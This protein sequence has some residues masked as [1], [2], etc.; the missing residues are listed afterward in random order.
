MWYEIITIGYTP[1]SSVLRSRMR[2]PSDSGS[3]SAVSTAA[4]AASA[5]YSTYSS[6]TPTATVDKP[7][8]W[9]ASAYV[10]APSVS[11]VNDTTPEVCCADS[12]VS[13][14]GKDSAASQVHTSPA[15]PFR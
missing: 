14:S 4:A 10:M 5:E 3:S 1:S 8:I 13:S 12:P 6:P 2:A 7:P 11:E 9:D 15:A